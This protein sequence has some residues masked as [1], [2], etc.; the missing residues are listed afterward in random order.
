MGNEFLALLEIDIDAPDYNEAVETTRDGEKAIKLI[1]PEP[2]YARDF[3]D[4]DGLFSVLSKPD[5]VFT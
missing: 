4:L 1:G 2:A 5:R 3:N